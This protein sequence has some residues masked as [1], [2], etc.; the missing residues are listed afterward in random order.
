MMNE[1]DASIA[2]HARTVVKHV[3]IAWDL[4]GL[5]AAAA[6]A[7]ADPQ[8]A[9]FR[10]EDVPDFAAKMTDLLFQ[11]PGNLKERIRDRMETYLRVY[12]TNADRR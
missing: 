12:L 11:D 8:V 10:L 5:Q 7:D 3:T 2:K 9:P 1:H 6:E 4:E